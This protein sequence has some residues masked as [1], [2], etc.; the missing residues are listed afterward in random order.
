MSKTEEKTKY[1]VGIYDDDEKLLHAVEKIRGRGYEIDD[2]FTPFPVHGLDHALGYRDS[3]LPDV[4]F[5][6]GALGCTI[7]LVMMT[8][9]YTFDWRVNVGGKPVFPFPNFIPITFELT[10]LI[11]S[12]GM[13]GTYLFVN[14]LS[15]AI[16]PEVV[17]PR[18]TDDRFVMVIK[19][20]DELESYNSEV[21]AAYKETG[22]I[23]TREQM[24]VGK[25]YNI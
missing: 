22:A 9:M 25:W 18:Q 8:Y 19:A 7:A 13:V 10:V 4:A 24:L 15:P 1:L 12:L 2:V 3:R 11:G 17:D 16:K 20:K 21:F 23:E 6:F 14:R 5:V